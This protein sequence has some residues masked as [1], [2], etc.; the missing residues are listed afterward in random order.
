MRSYSHATK[1]SRY[2]FYLN[3]KNLEHIFLSSHQS[4]QLKKD[5]ATADMEDL[6][7][8]IN[9]TTSTAQVLIVDSKHLK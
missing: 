4:S 1:S 7:E 8:A 2:V 6:E 3:V 5:S 9:N